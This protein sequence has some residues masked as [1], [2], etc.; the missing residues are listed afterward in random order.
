MS[1]TLSLVPLIGSV[2]PLPTAGDSLK[3]FFNESQN[4]R[5]IFNALGALSI[6]LYTF[7]MANFRPL[8]AVVPHIIHGPNTLGISGVSYV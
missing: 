3:I 6:V 4:V 1:L 8:A 5:S 2:R 7:I